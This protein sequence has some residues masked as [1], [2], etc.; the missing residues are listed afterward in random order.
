MFPNALIYTMNGCQYVV[1][2]C[3]PK[4]CPPG[5]PGPPGPQGPP[6]PKGDKGNRG[7]RGPEGPQ[8]IPGPQGPPGVCEGTTITAEE[9]ML[10]LRMCGEEFL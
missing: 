6:G 3:H 1:P 2:A 8:G 7:R 9:V 4:P 5:P 10:L